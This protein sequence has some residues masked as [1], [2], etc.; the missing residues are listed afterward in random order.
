MW[1]DCTAVTGDDHRGR[2]LRD[3]AVAWARIDPDPITRA[4]IEAMV[5]ASDLAALERAFGSRVRF[6]TA[7]LRASMGPGPSGINRV[8]V[9]RATAGLMRELSRGARVVVGHDARRNSAQFAA[10]TARVVAAH[11]GRALVLPPNAPTPLVA[12]AVRHLAADAGVMCTASHNPP[13]DNGYK[14]Y[15]HDGAQVIPPIDAR[16]A[17]AIDDAGDV[18]VAT[19]NDPAMV[20]LDAE[21]ENAYVEHIA[22]LPTSRPLDPTA[23]IGLVYSPLH[24]VGARPSLAAFDRAGFID[25]TVVDEQREPDGAFPTLRSPNPEDPSALALTMRCAERS[26]AVV[27]V[28]QDPDADRLGVVVPTPEGWRALT[29]DEIGL[30]LG[31]HVLRR[32]KGDDRLVVDTVVSSSAL[33][34]LAEAHRVHH[35]RTLTGFKWIVRPALAGNDRR[36]VFGYEEALGFSVDGY[37][38]DKD[39]ISSALAVAALAADQRSGGHTLTDRLRELAVAHGLFRTAAWTLRAPSQQVVADAM[40]SWRTSLPTSVGGL[41]V[42]RVED[43]AGGGD[44]PPTDLLVLHLEGR[45]RVAVRPSG[46]EPKLKMY[47]EV[48][49]N[50]A[51]ADD[52]DR[53]V[54]HADS[55]LDSLRDALLP[56]LEDVLGGA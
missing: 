52:Y 14:V 13:D 2:V 22:A 46:T 19:P 53:E 3:R 34:R 30:L 31:D 10:D 20:L 12:F 4:Q 7:G 6:G 18:A 1:A 40:R 35:T 36:F 16:I 5:H 48:V 17:R 15:L 51:R 47:A 21:V 11:G 25:V 50:V 45:A 9:R 8:V 24:G 26:D 38:R 54:A 39:G 32:T 29:G 28:V 23:R 44:L 37:V 49:S 55:R 43:F 41:R 27:A 42:E 56:L 33:A